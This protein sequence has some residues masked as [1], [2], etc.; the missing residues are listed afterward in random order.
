M[1]TNISYNEKRRYLQTVDK[2]RYLQTVDKR[3]YL[4]TVDKRRYLQTVD[5]CSP[6]DS[7]FPNIFHIKL[8]FFKL[9]S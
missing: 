3:R 8:L 6:H 4:Q 7:N 5:K 1:N 9:L 2:C